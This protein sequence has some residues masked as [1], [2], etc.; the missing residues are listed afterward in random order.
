MF[1]VEWLQPALD[2]LALLWTQ[3][4]SALRQVLAVASYE[5]DQRLQKNPRNQGESPTLGRRIRRLKKMTAPFSASVPF[6]APFL[7]VQ[8]GGRSCCCVG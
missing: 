6:S 7:N 4:D 5:I 2:E 8:V 1:R 3:A